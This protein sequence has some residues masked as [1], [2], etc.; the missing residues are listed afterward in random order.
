[1]KLSIL[2]FCGFLF[3]NSFSIKPRIFY[4]KMQKIQGISNEL[5]ILP[6]LGASYMQPKNISNSEPPTVKYGI[7]FPGITMGIPLNILAY[8]FTNMHY[9]ENI[10]TPKIA[11]LLCLLG[12]YTYGKDKIRDAIVYSRK[13]LE[14]N[15]YYESILENQD[16]LN[17][18]YGSFYVMF[19]FLLFEQNGIS[20]ETYGFLFL[21]EIS[22]FLYSLKYTFY[23]YYLGIHSIYFAW[24]YLTIL[25]FISQTHVFDHEFLFLPFL[26]LLDSTNHYVQI[27]QKIGS[28]KPLYVSA[29]WVSA[30]YILPAVIHDQNWAVLSMENLP[31]LLSPWFL[32][33]GLSNLADIKDMKDDHSQKINTIPVMYGESG[34]KI[35]SFL[36]LLSFYIFTVNN[37]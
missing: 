34:A 12:T 24:S 22:K 30:F 35:F 8:A 21:Y 11:F 25:V 18:I 2:Y 26:F 27:K 15:N 28:F 3:G 33:T 23:S 20:L 1:M 17:N 13:N 37:H 32:M 10:L 16:I 4:K 19:S 7:T 9:G 14:T 31:D 36:C 5:P 6:K 29:M